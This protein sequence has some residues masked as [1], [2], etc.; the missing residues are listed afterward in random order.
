M[1]TQQD[2]STSYEQKCRT[3]PKRVC[4]DDY[5]GVEKCWDESSQECS[6]EPNT[7]YEDS[8]REVPREQCENVR[9]TVDRVVPEQVCRDKQVTS[10]R[11]SQECNTVSKPVCRSVPRQECKNVPQVVEKRVPSEV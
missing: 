11:S 1:G 10:Y 9:K 2:C 8:C 5:Y 6:T 7:V 4:K 3:V